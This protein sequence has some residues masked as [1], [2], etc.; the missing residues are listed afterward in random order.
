M[1]LAMWLGTIY[2][3]Y[4]YFVDVVAGLG[5]GFCCYFLAPWLERNWP[6]FFDEEGIVRERRQEK[7]LTEAEKQIKR[8]ESLRFQREKDSKAAQE[9][10]QFPSRTQAEKTTET[11]R[12]LREAAGRRPSA[13][14]RQ[15]I[16]GKQKSSKLTFAQIRVLE[17]LLA[18]DK[19]LRGSA[20]T[21]IALN[22]LLGLE[23]SP[24]ET[25]LENRLNELLRQF[26]NRT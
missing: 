2:G 4:H 12:N 25:D 15:K 10:A 16:E 19:N 24:E 21:R 13:A 20:V 3:R 9:K 26:K 14:R 7:H 22:R 1:I 5:L 8:L 11:L 17:Q 6:L 23:N 18:G